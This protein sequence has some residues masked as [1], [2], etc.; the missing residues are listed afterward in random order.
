MP[1][2][3]V[4]ARIAAALAGPTARSPHS[5]PRWYDEPAWHELAH[6][7]DGASAGELLAAFGIANDDRGR[8][9]A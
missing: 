5:H 2:R 3:C 6:A 9:E 8:R 4:W 7:V 1:T